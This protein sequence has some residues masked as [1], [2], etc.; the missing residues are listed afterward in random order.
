[1]TS[2]G[3]AEEGSVKKEKLEKD[4]N[5]WGEENAM[6]MGALVELQRGT[7]NF[8][9]SIP[10]C[11]E[12]LDCTRSFLTK[13]SQVVRSIPPD[14]I[15][16]DDVDW[17]KVNGKLDTVLDRMGGR[18]MEVKNNPDCTLTLVSNI[19]RIAHEV[20]YKHIQEIKVKAKSPAFV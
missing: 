19:N 17:M 10:K 13:I 7:N 5:K 3:Q 9:V 4:D 20:P 14:S 15:E 12:S 18:K 8:D 1:M 2:H 6:L 11:D 16:R